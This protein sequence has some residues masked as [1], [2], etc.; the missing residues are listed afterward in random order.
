MPEQADAS[1][2]MS[3][4]E[5]RRKTSKVLSRG[6]PASTVSVVAGV[7]TVVAL[8][9]IPLG[10]IWAGLAPGQRMRVVSAGGDLVPLQLE[11]WHR[12]DALAIFVLLAFATGVLT[13]AGVWLLRR[14]RG[15][16]ILLAAVAG[17]LLAAWLAMRIGLAVADARYAI[18]DSPALGAVVERAPVLE[19][20]WAVVSA[21]MTTALLYGMLATCSTHSDLGTHSGGEH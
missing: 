4:A 13:G 3:P 11:S 17:S 10:W 9:G 7:L 2:S 1:W 6:T 5:S 18:A 12:F 8:L 20:G 21:P 14:W 19:S 15:P 16:L